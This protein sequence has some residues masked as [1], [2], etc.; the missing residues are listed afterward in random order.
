MICSREG[1]SFASFFMPCAVMR[2]RSHIFSLSS[3]RGS[4]NFIFQND[5]VVENDQKCI[6][7]FLLNFGV[8]S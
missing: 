3:G 7:K 8:P 4:I 5:S 1:S 6:M 2:T